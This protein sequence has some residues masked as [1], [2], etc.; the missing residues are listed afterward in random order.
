MIS[1][2]KSRQASSP[3][4][5]GTVPP[6]TPALPPGVVLEEGFALTYVYKGFGIVVG[7]DG[8]LAIESDLF[9]P[10]ITFKTLQAAMKEIDLIC[11]FR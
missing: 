5:G 4:P 1:L 3:P 10:G 11:P 8:T 2:F 9:E 7:D 6:P